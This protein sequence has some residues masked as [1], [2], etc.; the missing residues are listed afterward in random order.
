MK[1]KLPVNLQR[2]RV[3]LPG[4]V[5]MPNESIQGAFLIPYGDVPIVQLKVMSGCGEG[6]DHV[7]VSVQGR[8][9]TWDE[10]NW[11]RGLF[12]EPEETVIQIH[13]PAS[14]YVNFHK[15]TLHL[16]RSWSQKVE[17]PP[18]WMI[19]PLKD[20]LPYMNLLWSKILNQL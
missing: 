11:I 1:D 10:M 17:L 20:Q 12:F 3:D 16:W 18:Q 6:W 13:A 8:C 5:K 7:S 4:Y 9:A 14:Q 2:Y 15:H 19:A